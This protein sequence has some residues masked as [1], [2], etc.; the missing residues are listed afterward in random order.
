MICGFDLPSE[1][2][3]NMISFI[4]IQRLDYSDAMLQ[5]R[6]AK[7]KQ[8]YKE[9]GQKFSSRESLQE[10]IGE[11]DLDIEYLKKVVYFSKN[12]DLTLRVYIT[13]IEV[14]S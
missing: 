6:D 9:L 1:T 3:N 11:L 5:F 12:L 7:N 4:L 13:I 8:F 10:H 2:F 14:K